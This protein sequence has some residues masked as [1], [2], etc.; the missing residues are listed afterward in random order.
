MDSTWNLSI[1]YASGGSLIQANTNYKIHHGRAREVKKEI[2]S[3][4]WYIQVFPREEKND[5]ESSRVDIL[6][7]IVKLHF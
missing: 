1:L 4:L 6:R 7:S 3:L 2:M 5:A